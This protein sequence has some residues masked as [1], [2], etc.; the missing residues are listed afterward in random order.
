ML[1]GLSSHNLSFFFFFS[2]KETYGEDPYMSGVLSQA[3]VS[4]LQ[5]DNP[6]YV[7][8]SAGCKHFDAYAGPENIPQSRHNFSAQVKYMNM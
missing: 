7:L 4:G 2:L 5:G 3:F 1:S 6:R 8:A